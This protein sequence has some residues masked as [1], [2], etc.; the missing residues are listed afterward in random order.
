M[1]SRLQLTTLLANTRPV[2]TCFSA[3]NTVAYYRKTKLH[4]KEFY[5]ICLGESPKWQNLSECEE[6]K[7]KKRIIIFCN[8]KNFWGRSKTDLIYSEGRRVILKATY[9]WLLLVAYRQLV[10]SRLAS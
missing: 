8:K 7:L 3:T 4:A 10:L 2:V 6:A 1:W 9:L 5:S